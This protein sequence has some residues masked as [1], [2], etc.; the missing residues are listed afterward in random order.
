MGEVT[1][2]P[3][4]HAADAVVG[5]AAFVATVAYPGSI[6]KRQ[7]IVEAGR[8]YCVKVAVYQQPEI[9]VK[10]RLLQVS[11]AAI[12]Q[13]FRQAAYILATRRFPGGV[14]ALQRLL[15]GR[16]VKLE[17]SRQTGRLL[18]APT[19]TG[20]GHTALAADVARELQEK[21]KYFAY[22]RTATSANTVLKHVWS[23]TRPVLHLALALRGLMRERGLGA[24]D[25]P[26]L[27]FVQDPIALLKELVESGET[28]RRGL[29]DQPGLRLTGVEPVRLIA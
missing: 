19:V 5:I 25:W 24:Y 28:W 22:H 26:D 27:F 16:E 15:G 14:M 4:D 9:P 10:A 12:S 17:F 6:A 11:D 23:E 21:S 13:Q 1:R 20:K 3:F 18:R 7:K 29:F 8:A 2:L